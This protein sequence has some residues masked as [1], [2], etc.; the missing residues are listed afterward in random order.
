MD[1]KPPFAVEDRRLCEVAHLALLGVKRQEPASRIYIFLEEILKKKILTYVALLAIVAAGTFGFKEIKRYMQDK[2]TE[3]AASPTEATIDYSLY[4][5]YADVEIIVGHLGNTDSIQESL[6]RL[7]DPLTKS[8]PITVGYIKDVATTVAV[9][10]SVYSEVLAGM[11]NTDYVEKSQ[12][13]E[14]YGNIVATGRIKGLL[15]QDLFVMTIQEDTTQFDTGTS[16]YN[17]EFELDPE[18]EGKI[19]DVYMKNG[20]IFKL[21]G[22]AQDE[23]VLENVWIN[24]IQDGTCDFLYGVQ[25]KSYP[26]GADVEIPEPIVDVQTASDATEIDAVASGTDAEPLAYESDGFVANITLNNEG[27]TEISRLDVVETVHVLDVTDNGLQVENMGTIPLAE[28]YRIYNVYEVP[29]CEESATLLTGYRNIN[30]YRKDNEIAAI[31]I[32]EQMVSE[33]IRVII[34]NDDYS[35]YEMETVSVTCT[36]PFKVNYPD[37]HSLSF[38]ADA[39]VELESKTFQTGDVIQVKPKLHTGRVQLLNVV[40]E[41]GN[42]LYD[43]VVELDCKGDYF[44]VI[45][46][47]SLERYLCN[48]VANAI[49]SDAPEEALKSVAICARA[50]AYAKLKDKSYAE[51]NAHLDDSSLCQVYNNV[52]ETEETIRAVKDTYGIVPV[53]KGTLIVPLTFQVSYGMTC[54]NSDIWGGD[55]YPYLISNVES[56]D[57]QSLD[58]SDEKDFRVFME[59]SN[60]YDIIDKNSPFYRWSVSFT[61]KEIT[62]AVETV[63]EERKELA[64][65]MILVKGDDDAFEAGDFTD[66]GDVKSIEITERSASGVV[67]MMEIEGSEKTIQIT[68]QSNIR[69][70]LSPVKQSIK[71]QDDTEVTGWTSLPSPFYYVDKTEDGYTIYGGG[72]GHGVGMSIY[73]ASVLARQGSNYKYIL[74][75]YYSYI[76]FKSIY[77]TSVEE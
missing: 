58:L 23:V 9:P 54:T 27:I 14:V 62:E 66:I 6:S 17:L 65:D 24:K 21:N 5:S 16:V 46:E 7:V 3:Q 32:N 69:N 15:R 70:I 57:K 39:V 47:L 76:D 36:S 18:Y 37:G 77:D 55:E 51:Y 49:P 38:E 20:K 41:C 63:L 72:F 33:D 60:G 26:I 50:N 35:S 71:K 52:Q 42:P 67:T 73:G 30:I 12:F 64:A 1:V 10:D 28:H 4:Y 34:S 11:D 43:G 25:E 8:E 59:D 45:N 13:E 75:H 56:K 61:E 74:R 53:Y 68:G 2:K 29:K 31:V 44:Y 19:I 40:R 22:L 48:V